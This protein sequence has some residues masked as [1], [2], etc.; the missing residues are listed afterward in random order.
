M[1]LYLVYAP[2][3]PDAPRVLSELLSLDEV[4]TALAE[5]GSRKTG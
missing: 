1:P 4:V 3:E 2:G 5:S